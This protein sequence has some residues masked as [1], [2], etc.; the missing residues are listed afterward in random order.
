M[1]T[2]AKDRNFFMVFTGGL[3]GSI[4]EWYDFTVYVYLAPI[5]AH[6]F[7]PHQNAYVSM[8]MAYA[9]FAVGYV[10]RPIGAIF[11]GHYGDRI[12]RRKILLFT[13]LMMSLTTFA[14]GFLPLYSEVGVLSPLLLIT[15]R[16]VQGFSTAG[17]VVG[18]ITYTF[19]SASPRHRGFWSTSL[20]VGSGFGVLIASFIVAAVAHSFS[21]EEMASWGWRLP[22]IFGLLTGVIGFLIRRKTPESV[23]F[24][25]MVK[26]GE[27]LSF[28]TLGVLKNY[29]IPLLKILVIFIPSAVNY[30]IFF[31]FLPT[32]SSDFLGHSLPDALIVNTITMSFLF[33]FTP[34]FAFLS[35]RI[36]RRPFLLTGLVAN[37]LLSITLF[38]LIATGTLIH[39]FIAQAIFSIIHSIYTAAVLST[40]LES[41]PTRIRFSAMAIAYNIAYAIFGG[42]APL[43]V[44]Y[45][46]HRNKSLI[47]PSF[48]IIFLACIA[49]LAVLKMRETH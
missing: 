31:I 17:E 15:L 40:S 23:Y 12:G 3:L 9:V 1:E 13:I 30:Y 45:L 47:S 41:V 49:L 29:K 19:E 33:I 38:N 37:I 18:A 14:I 24:S 46:I 44:T 27:V 25:A 22:F 35:D 28:P 36:G 26:R 42:T 48:Y 5:I 10:V 6:L 32:Y 2:I 16:M 43:V 7:F 39:F 20:W 34:I 8:L 21:T 11:F 4:M